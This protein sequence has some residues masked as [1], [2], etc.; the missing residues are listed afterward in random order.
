MPI[1]PITNGLGGATTRTSVNE[2]IAAINDLAPLFTALGFSMRFRVFTTSGT[3]N[4]PVGCVF[5]LV[6]ALG[7]G[8]GGG[9]CAAA[10]NRAGSG[11]GAG[12]LAMTGVDV[13]DIASATVT[14]GAGGVGA[15]VGTTTPTAGG[16]SSWSGGAVT[17]TGNGGAAGQNDTTGNNLEGGA[18]GGASGA[19]LTI[20][21]GN[22]GITFGSVLPLSGAGGSPALGLGTGGAQRIAQTWA[23]GR[24]GQGYG[25]GGSGSVNNS[26]TTAI[27]A[28]N[29]KQG[30]VLVLEGYGKAA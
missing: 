22:G 23:G 12:G 17:L 16:N 14:V 6:I 20:P 9:G 19:L 24:N 26:N 10:A 25:S 11:G 15:L 13:R 5:A 21:G 28:G 29:G 3:W 18:G 4:R 8:G 2:A 1:N 30:L 27:Q 7:G